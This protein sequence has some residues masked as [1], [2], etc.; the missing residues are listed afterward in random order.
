MPARPTLSEIHRVLA[1]RL[2]LVVHFSGTPKGAGSDFTH[3]FPA[4]LAEVI[5]GTSQ[6]GL[7]CST[8]LPGDE[9]DDLERANATGCVGVVLG[10]MT[11]D[12]VLDAHPR[13]CGSYMVDGLRQVPHARDMTM[14]D[15]D[16]TIA[17]RATD[18]Y[19]EW[20]IADYRVIGLFVAEP[21]RVSV[22]SAIHYPDDMPD[23]LR[24]SGTAPGF[25]CKSLG[26]IEDMFPQTPI[27]SFSNGG[28]AR[29]DGS[30]WIP[31]YHGSLYPP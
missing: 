14:G 24:D 1:N 13:D 12:S 7:S 8:V 5:K 6:S 11:P 16:A 28:L 18:S 2:A 29:W 20:V 30:E 10:P 23:Y 21:H 26:E 17:G 9:F 25:A 15:L 27:Y 3:L 31:A 19:N 22:E 4:D